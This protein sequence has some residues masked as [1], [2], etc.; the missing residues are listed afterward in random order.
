MVLL[1]M[2]VFIGTSTNKFS[3]RFANLFCYSV[4][5]L[6]QGKDHTKAI[7]KVKNIQV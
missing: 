2:P 4:A 1:C 3:P 5:N 7:D 6:L